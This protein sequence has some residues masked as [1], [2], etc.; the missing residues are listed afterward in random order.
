ME[1]EGSDEAMTAFILLLLFLFLSCMIGVAVI[2]EASIKFAIFATFLFLV[3]VLVI[4][5]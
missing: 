1:S 3:V 4:M 2:L 5:G